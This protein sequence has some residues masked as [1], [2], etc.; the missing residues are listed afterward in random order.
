MEQIEQKKCFD[1]KKM[2]PRDSF[3]KNCKTKDGLQHVCR[4]CMKI[5]DARHRV[6][7]ADGIKT[8]NKAYRQKNDDKIRE[9]RAA[10][11][12]ANSAYKKEHRKK[13]ID[14][15]RAYRKKYY[16]ENAEVCKDKSLRY[17]NENKEVI[18]E[19][20]K[21]YYQRNIDAIRE[22]SRKYREEHKEERKSAWSEYR[23]NNPEKVRI[24]SERYRS[25]K[26]ELLADF[27]IVDWTLCQFMF[28][29]RCAYCGEWSEDLIQEHVIPVSKGGHYVPENIIPACRSCN[30]S[31]HA[32]DM[33]EWYRK[34]PF[35]EP[36]RLDFIERYLE[37]Y[38]RKLEK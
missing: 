3:R 14:K 9:K 23:K 8:N 36:Y 7:N 11:K 25:R 17:Y 33:E 21:D 29:C 37:Q 38:A 16:H 20:N 4:E 19:K 32:R 6:E 2:L 13:N 28:E 5:R 10:N 22:R 26:N 34:Q 12:E 35:F 27:N 18:A 1:C 15:I 30:G 31:K 24:I